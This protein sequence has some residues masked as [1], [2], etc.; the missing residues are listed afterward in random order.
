MVTGEWV[1]LK[2]GRRLQVTVGTSVFIH[3]FWLADIEDAC[4]MGLRL[5]GPIYGH[6]LPSNWLGS[7]FLKERQRAVDVPLDQ[8]REQAA[9]QNSP[10]LTLNE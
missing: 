6:G 1:V 2:G 7:H 8:V 3:E 5:V 10:A 9:G 4:I